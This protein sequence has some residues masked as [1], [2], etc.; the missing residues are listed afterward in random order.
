MRSGDSK[1]SKDKVLKTNQELKPWIHF[2]LGSVQKLKKVRFKPEVAANQQKSYFL[3]YSSK[4][5]LDQSQTSVSYQSKSVN[6]KGTDYIELDNIE[7]RYIKIQLN[8]EIPQSL[9]LSGFQFSAACPPPPNPPEDG[10]CDNG[11]FERGNFNGWN[12]ENAIP[13]KNVPSYFPKLHRGKI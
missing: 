6:L 1:V 10:K 8:E 5:P 2:D 11:G 4:Q 7:A 12:Y 3:F 13:H 9:A